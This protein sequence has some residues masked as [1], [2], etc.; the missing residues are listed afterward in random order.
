MF[1][2]GYYNDE[3]PLPL[4]LEERR[5]GGPWNVQVRCTPIKNYFE[6]PTHNHLQCV[7]LITVQGKFGIN[8]ILT[9]KSNDID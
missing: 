6:F 1:S 5:G 4:D 8:W 9:Q 2:N 3:C 7:A